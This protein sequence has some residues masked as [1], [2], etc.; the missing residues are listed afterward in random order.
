MNDDLTEIERAH[1]IAQLCHRLAEESWRMIE[2]T[3]VRIA[4]SRCLMER[5]DALRAEV[6]RLLIG[7]GRG[8]WSGAA[9]GQRD[10]GEGG[11]GDRRRSPTP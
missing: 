8:Q 4:R 5:H 6:A 1:A 2:E 7:S 11:T 3:Q 10:Q 9:L